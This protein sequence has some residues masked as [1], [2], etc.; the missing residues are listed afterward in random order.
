MNTSLLAHLLALRYRLL[1][2]S[3]RVRRGKLVLFFV[4]YL[5]VM[6]VIAFGASGGVKAARIAMQTGQ[7]ELVAQ[8]VL[9]GFFSL[10]MM[11][12]VVLGVGMDS[13]FS[14]VELRRYPLKPLERLA[15][16][17]LTAILDPL[18]MI[19]AALY[20]SFGIGLVYYGVAAVPRALLGAV[21][22]LPA[23]Y[24][25]AR[26]ILTLVER[27]MATRNGQMFLLVFVMV[28]ALAPSLLMPY[29]LRH[30]AG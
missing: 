9:S 18:W 20:L 30:F 21:L 13:V 16:R 6:L 26:V 27:L 5:I 4:F 7:A 8:I 11:C 2:A 12:A 3:V 17:Q 14:D 19:M 10:A 24:L 25:F 23:N 22:L 29:F 28:L 1:W 15:A